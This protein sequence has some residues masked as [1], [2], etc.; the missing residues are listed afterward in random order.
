MY[1]FDH[2]VELCDYSTSNIEFSRTFQC[3]RTNN[4]RCA[5]QF[6]ASF[7]LLGAER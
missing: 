6:L 7:N 4:V 5:L 1:T 2:E 3:S